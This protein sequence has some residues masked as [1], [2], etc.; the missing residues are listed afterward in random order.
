MLRYNI[1]SRK[2]ALLNAKASKTEE[3][4]QY[5]NGEFDKLD[6]VLDFLL[7][8]P[9]TKTQGAE[10]GVQADD[11]IEEGSSTNLLE[12]VELHDPDR[13][14]QKGRPA[15]PT[16]LNPLIEE[17]RQKNGKRRKEEGEQEEKGNK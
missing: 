12:L 10:S 4:M 7:S 11:T 15:L 3:A 8:T 9:N 2:A 14:K 16:R 13:V 17:I 1:L 5:L 6:S